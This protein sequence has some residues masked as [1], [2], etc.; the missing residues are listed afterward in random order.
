MSIYS[1]L[2]EHIFFERHSAGDTVVPFEREDLRTAAL[3]L[4]LELP[5]NLG[6][7]IYSFRSR[8]PLPAS[9]LETQP[10][11][12]EW[13][14]EG[15][16]TSSYVFVLAP[17]NRIVPRPNLATTKIPEATPEIVSLYAL[18]DEQG[19]LAKLRYNRIIDL[20]L[21][22]VAYS[23]QNHL[24]TTVRGVGGIE[25]D[26][27][28]VGVDR[29][30]RHYVAPV[31]AKAGSDQITAVQAKNDI[32]YCREKF[33]NLIC[34]PIAAQFVREDLIALFELTLGEDGIE[35]V[36]E[37]HYQLVPSEEIRDSDLAA[38]KTRG[39]P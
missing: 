2:I 27:L 31:Q 11:D 17:I 36:D 12:K 30:G 37:R 14:I 19:L 23:L 5:K 15:T 29:H 20:F 22:I 21:G 25:I 10:E 6:D 4:K 33:P 35:V 13:V 7:V 38:Y 34:R 8:R 16:G 26:E 32:L 18:T 3:T 24:K 28:Y 9:I 39:V 1:D